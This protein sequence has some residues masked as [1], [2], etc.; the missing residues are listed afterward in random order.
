MSKRVKKRKNLNLIIRDCCILKVRFF[1]V[2][3][4][5]LIWG[6]YL[7]IIYFKVFRV[8]WFNKFK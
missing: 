4:D 1:I 7:N 6:Y 3:N 2:F 5:N 8:N